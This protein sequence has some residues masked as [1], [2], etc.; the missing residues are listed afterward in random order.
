MRRGPSPRQVA[1]QVNLGVGQTTWILAS[2]PTLDWR[3]HSGC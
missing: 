2:S 3:S 1:L